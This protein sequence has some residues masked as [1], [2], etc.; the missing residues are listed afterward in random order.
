[1]PNLKFR[2]QFQFAVFR[3]VFK[4]ALQA[5]KDNPEDRKFFSTTNFHRFLAHLFYLIEPI[6][7][8]YKDEIDSVFLTVI[9][10]LDVIYLDHSL[11]SLTDQRDA[12]AEGTKNK[13]I[14]VFSQIEVEISSESDVYLKHGYSGYPEQFLN[15]PPIQYFLLKIG[16]IHEC[17]F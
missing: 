11:N 16:D 14:D 2:R 6:S 9:L 7:P 12:C 15:Q 13:E 8:Q 17:I 5:L 3:V 10:R 4:Q 1:M